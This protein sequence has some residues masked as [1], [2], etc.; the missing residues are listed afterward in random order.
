MILDDIE[1]PGNSMTELMREKLLQLCTEAE[2][3]ITPKDDSRIMY[4]GTPQTTFTVY[5]RLAERSYKPFV[6]PARY[7]RKASNYEGLLAPQLVEDIEKG[8]DKWDVTDDRFDN[9][10]LIEREASM[11]RSNFMSVSYNH[12]TLPTKRI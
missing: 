3:I 5:K 12:L 11:G 7:P 8:A 1:V 2:S 4:L 10:D 6:W 9:E